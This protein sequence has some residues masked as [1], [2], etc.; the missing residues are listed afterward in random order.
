[1]SSRN[2]SSGKQAIRRNI[3]D[4]QT[5]VMVFRIENPY[6]SE[7]KISQSA[8]QVIEL[9]GMYHAELAR[10]LCQQCADIGQLSAGTSCIQK[11]TEAWHR[12]VLFIDTYHLLYDL[13]NADSVAMYHWMRAHNKE[14]DGTPHFLIVDENKLQLVHDY[15]AQKLI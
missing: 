3:S 9:L 13:F 14:L 2:M 10:I 4:R 5:L 6:G 11:N 12:A 15:L 1:M 7:R 8:I